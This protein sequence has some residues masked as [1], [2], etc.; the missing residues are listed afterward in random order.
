[1]FLVYYLLWITFNGRVTTEIL[2]LGLPVCAL[3]YWFS[4]RFL[5]I[6]PKK[7]I[8]RINRIPA[9]AAYLFFLLKEIILS[10]LKVMKL[11]WSP[12][13]PVHPELRQFS[14]GL[15]TDAGNVTLA[16]SITLTPG[17]ITVH[18]EGDLLTVHC[19][20]T[21][22]GEGIEDSEMLHKIRKLEGK[23]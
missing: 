2:L 15:K 3:L 10:S 14:S 22:T 20:D 13:R 19:L 7:E 12:S 17:T 21:A 11:I 8:L 16:D 18:A 6:S 23:H 5:G 9:I 4:V 1:M